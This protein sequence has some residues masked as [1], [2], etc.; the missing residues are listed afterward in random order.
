MLSSLPAS[1][2]VKPASVRIGAALLL[3]GALTTAVAVEQAAQPRQRMSLGNLAASAISTRHGALLIT[4]GKGCSVSPGTMAILENLA[5]VPGFRV[6]HLALG[7]EAPLLSRTL[8]IAAHDRIVA[9][10]WS[11]ALPEYLEYPLLIVVHDGEVQGILSRALAGDV[12]RLRAFLDVRKH[13]ET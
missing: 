5:S 7:E 6:V 10:Q 4:D 13:S 11:Q 9:E 3:A 2:A 1:R 12:T 8:S